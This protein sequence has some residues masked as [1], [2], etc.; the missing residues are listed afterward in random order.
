MK[1]SKIEFYVGFSVQDQNL[2]FL[3]DDL[4]DKFEKLAK[5]YGGYIGGSGYGGG[6]RDYSAYFTTD[7]AAVRFRNHIKKLKKV[8]K[9]F[10]YSLN[11]QNEHSYESMDI[12]L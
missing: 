12:E 9:K 7:T 6:S 11:Y 2:D 10:Y 3:F 8:N 5:K 4:D 1:K